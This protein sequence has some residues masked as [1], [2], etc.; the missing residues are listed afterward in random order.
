[1]NIAKEFV[2]KNKTAFIAAAAVY[3]GALILGSVLACRLEPQQTDELKAYIV[4]YLSADAA[5]Q[6]SHADIF[7][8]SASA[9]LRFVAVALVCAA[10]T[11]LL[12][13]F[14]FAFGLTGYRIGFAIAFISDNFGVGGI[15]L[16]LSSALVSCLLAVPIYFLIFVTEINYSVKR[17]LQNCTSDAKKDFF[18]FAVFAVLMYFLL[19]LASAAEAWITPFIIG[20]MN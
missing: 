8:S 11:F 14:I 3:F 13:L 2:I 19:C 7:V 17:K 6:L 1:M 5:T 16:A 4:P 12:P 18:A 20:I 10:S 9:H 15:A